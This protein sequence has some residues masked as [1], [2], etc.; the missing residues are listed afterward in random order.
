MNDS[1]YAD[2][3][4]CWKERSKKERAML[5]T[6]GIPPY[7]KMTRNRSGNSERDKPAPRKHQA[8]MLSETLE[9]EENSRIPIHFPA[10]VLDDPMCAGQHR[11]SARWDR[12]DA[13]RGS[14][15]FGSRIACRSPNTG[16]KC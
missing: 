5:L 4:E 9:P 12:V 1:E 13:L 7:W 3:Q 6:H 14:A 16:T 2:E 8:H 15:A 10:H 11:N